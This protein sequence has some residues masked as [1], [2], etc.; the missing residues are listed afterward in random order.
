MKKETDSRSSLGKKAI[1]WALGAFAVCVVVGLIAVAALAAN[2]P[3][4]DDFSVKKITQSTK[5]YDRTG[6]VLLYEIHGEEK[7]TLIPPEDVPDIVKKATLA[8]EDADFYNQPAFDWKSIVRAVFVNLQSGRYAQGGSTITQQLAKNIFLTNEKTFTRKAKELILAVQLEN[9]YTKD[10]ILYFYLNQIPYGSNAYGIEAAAQTFFGK[11]AKDLELHEAA[12]IVSLAQAPSYYSPY[13]FHVDDLMDRKNYVLDQMTKLGYISKDEAD[14]AKRKEL[15]FLPQ[16]IGSIRAPHF[17]LMVKQ[18]LEEKY[19]DEDLTQAGYKVITTLDWK[20]QEIAE[21]VVAEGAANNE[22]NYEGRNA[23]LVAEDPKTGQILTLVGS[24]DYFDDTIRGNYNVATQGLR[25]PGSALKPYVYLTAFE[26]GYTPETLLFDAKTEFDTRGGSESY[27][28]ENFDGIFR[29]PI[30]MQSALAQSLNVPAVKTLY[31]A[32][33]QNSLDT[34]HNFGITTLNDRDR[35]SLTLVLGGGEVHLV[36]LV[37]AYATMSQE[38]V[39]HDQSIILKIENTSGDTVE[40]WK[41]SEGT[42]VMEPENPRRINHILS[43]QEL[44]SGLF[45]SS[46]GLTIFPG[47][48]VALKTGTTQDY[49]DAWAFGYTPSL[50]VGVWAGNTDNKPMVRKGGSILAAIPMWSNFLREALKN[51]P[52]E[53][54]PAPDSSPAIS[55]PMLNGDYVWMN[56]GVPEA[57]SI[58]YYVRKDDPRGAWPE[59]PASDPQFPGWEDGV[60]KWIQENN[61]GLTVP[62]T[63]GSGSTG[64]GTGA[65][66]GY[67]PPGS[68]PLAPGEIR[69][70]VVEPSDGS[71]MSGPFPIRASI[72]S[73]DELAL[74]QLYVNGSLKNQLN[75]A[76]K[77][78]EYQYYFYQGLAAENRFEIRVTDQKNRVQSRKFTVYA[79]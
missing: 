51:Y 66:N 8:A 21:R 25:Q 64:T 29:G 7:R 46:L 16:S 62:G 67:F 74:I 34:L 24:R 28:P 14:A 57:H 37:N 33:L 40:E 27:S 77:S 60:R 26:K 79:H 18:Y 70:G 12:L 5:I 32:G 41:E 72:S 47:Y 75:I 38:G 19:G 48:D 56:N 3:S 6:E 30:A 35:Y 11:H 13:G 73:S 2:L 61:P 69:I 42:R 49:R 4:P 43:S 9:R 59:N 54:F 52:Q 50:T 10:E 68:V 39:R 15:V 65:E 78:F 45:Q 1:T 44:R 17:S 71:T 76:G 22:K 23:S 20:L 53:S 31:L 58:L 63:S 55:K 36:D